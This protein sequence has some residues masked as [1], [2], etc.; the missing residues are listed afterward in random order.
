MT[1]TEFL[2]WCTG[3]VR[4]LDGATGTNMRLCGAPAGVCMEAWI[5]QHPEHL[6]ALQQRYVEAGSELVYAPTFGGNRRNLQ[7]F[8]LEQELERMNAQLVAL[9]RKAAGDR[10]LVA[11]DLTTTGLPVLEDGPMHY[12]DLLELYLEQARCL[13]AAGVDLFVVETMMGV[14]ESMAA[15]EAIRGFSDKPIMVSLSLQSDGKCYFDGNAETAAQNLQALGAD[16][17]GVNCSSGPDQLD[18]VL[19]IF[20]QNSEL[21][22][23]VKPNA[24]LPRMEPD[25]SAVY[26]MGPAEFAG[27]MK[28]LADSRVRLMGG[29]CGTTPDYIRALKD[30]L[31]G[32]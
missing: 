17:I 13:D 32:I 7:N 18:S 11:G 31:S 21:P 4:L 25:G 14:L 2:N 15:V 30:A 28:K 1:R 26:P 24:G 16:A 29:C 19:S 8:G 6:T 5:L 22:L 12:E 9:S 10:A 23:L 27:H 3:S 20:R